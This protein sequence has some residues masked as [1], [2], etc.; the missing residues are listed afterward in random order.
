[1]IIRNIFTGKEYEAIKYNQCNSK[2]VDKVK[3]FIFEKLDLP[4]RIVGSELYVFELR[5]IGMESKIKPADYIIRGGIDHNMYNVI[6]EEI[7][8]EN[9]VIVA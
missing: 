9:F 7:F 2:E 1:M 3:N 4:F 6:S 5:F 8:K